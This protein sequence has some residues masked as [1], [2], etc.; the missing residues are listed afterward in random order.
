MAEDE[1]SSTEGSAYK[2]T[3]RCEGR[4]YET[5]ANRTNRFLRG[6]ERM[7]NPAR[8]N[9]RMPQEVCSEP[10]S[11]CNFIVLARMYPESILV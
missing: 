2:R 3:R 10:I 8:E 1:S 6:M 7:A 5:I 4:E 9:G 11:L